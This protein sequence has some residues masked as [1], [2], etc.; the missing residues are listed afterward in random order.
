MQGHLFAIIVLVYVAGA[1][2]QECKFSPTTA[3]GRYA[4]FGKLCKGQLIFQEHFDSFNTEV[5]ERENDMDDSGVSF[6]Y[7]IFIFLI[8]LVFVIFC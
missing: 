5:W 1:S 7:K 8:Y 3:S 6:F 2:C 4:P